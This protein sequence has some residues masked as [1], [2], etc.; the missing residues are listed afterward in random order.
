M[1]NVALLAVERPEWT[2]AS[3]DDWQEHATVEAAIAA[4]PATPQRVFSALGRSSLAAL[5][6]A[7]Q[8]HYFIRVI[9]PIA[10]PSRLPHA[11]IITAR[12]PIRTEEDTELFRTHDIQCI[13]AKNSGGNAAYAKIEAARRLGL[14]VHIV[15]R[16]AIP[17][18]PT[19]TSVDDAM[20]WL[21]THHSPRADR[22]V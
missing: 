21:A 12:G 8:H 2:R 6:A 4:L 16:P 13:L 14:K 9:D 20:A 15:K 22:G 1:T 19:V 3:G 11:T 10:P 17:A 18:R 7:P 5:C